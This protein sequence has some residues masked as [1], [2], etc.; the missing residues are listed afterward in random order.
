MTQTAS[1]T[2]CDNAQTFSN[3]LKQ[4]T[5]TTH[6]SLDK[7]IMALNPFAD[8]QGYAQFVRTQARLHRVVSNWYQHESM[9]QQL[10]QLR[11]R[12]RLDAVLQDCHD[13]AISTEQLAQDQQAAEAMQVSDPYAA[14]GWL[15]TVEGSNL[16]AAFLLKYARTQL[17]LSEDFGARHLAAHKDGR[18]LHWRQFKAALDGL[19]LTEE[20]RQSALTG[21][22]QAFTFARNNVE[23]LLAP[24]AAQPEFSDE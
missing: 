8:R 2:T 20:Q 21:A 3:W 19:Q 10:P 11:Q 14:I 4:E 6:E 17:D 7:R 15:Y 5:T 18:G 13:F 23:Q 1:P 24:L 12:D 22:R 9:Q 16:G